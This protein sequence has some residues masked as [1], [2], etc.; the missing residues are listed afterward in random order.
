MK[1]TIVH[2]SGADHGGAERQLLA[3][4]K[5]ALS[6]AGNDYRHEVVLVRE[7]PLAADFA[8][9]VPTTVLAKGRPLDFRFLRELRSAL[10]RAQPAIV[11]SWAPTPNL[12]GPIV[13]KSLTGRSRPKTVLAEVGLDEWKGRLLKL[14][15]RLSYRCADL[16]VGCAQAVT[17]AAIRRGAAAARTD[18]VYLGV[19]LPP[20]PERAP[21]RGRVQLLGRVDFRKGHRLLLEIWPEVKAAFPAAELVLAGPAASAEELEL[22]AD[23]LDQIGRNPVLADSVRMIDRVDPAEYLAQ[24]EVLVVPSTS[25][26]LPNVIL[27]AF[28]H[29]VPV[30]ATDVGGIGELVRDG[31]SGWLV[32]AGD[33]DA[34]RDALLAA[35]ADRRLAQDRADAGR[36]RVAEMDLAASLAHWE[37]I[38][39]RLLEPAR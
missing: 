29:R 20:W 4:L 1:P 16:V 3:L 15:D 18:T 17:R 33:R 25:E 5:T 24:A 36:A 9:L 38:Y 2:L 8:A 32:P 22:R 37:E 12:W 26:G 27:E 7:G 31:H 35:L 19:Q 14:A 34:F 13:A 23:L 39:A 10:Q 6:G 11:H 28:S 30:I 21:I